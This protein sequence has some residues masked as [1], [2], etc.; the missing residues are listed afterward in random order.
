MEEIAAI[1]PRLD[2]LTAWAGDVKDYALQQ[3]LSGTFYPGFK[4]A[5]GQ[6]VR[7]YVDDAAAAKAGFD[8]YEKKILGITTMAKL[9]GRKKFDEALGSLLTKPQGKAVLVPES[10]KRPAVNTAY[11]DFKED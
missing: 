4:V 9:M 8:P 10:D 2:E 7:K 11:E 3:V 5:E 6:F 1:L